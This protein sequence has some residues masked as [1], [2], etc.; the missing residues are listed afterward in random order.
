MLGHS[1]L[2]VFVVRFIL[3]TICPRGEERRKID[4]GKVQGEVADLLEILGAAA[5]D[6]VEEFGLR[7]EVDG[8]VVEEGLG[9]HLDLVAGC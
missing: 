2:L 8:P 6:P 7:G 5:I 1:I 4:I 3:S 9:F